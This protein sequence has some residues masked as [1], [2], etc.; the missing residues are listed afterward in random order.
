MLSK[1]IP[2]LLVRPMAL[3]LNHMAKTNGKKN[4]FTVADIERKAYLE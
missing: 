1:E 4:G 2:R 3:L